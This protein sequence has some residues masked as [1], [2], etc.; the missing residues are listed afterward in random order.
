MADLTTMEVKNKLLQ[1]RLKD[2]WS[3]GTNKL[4]GASI[5]CTYFT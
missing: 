3:T 4:Y 5:F 1:K 2:W